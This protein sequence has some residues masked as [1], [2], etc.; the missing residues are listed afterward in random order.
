MLEREKEFRQAIETKRQNVSDCFTETQPFL[1]SVE[2]E[3]ESLR[4]Q[5]HQVKQDITAVLE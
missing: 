1:Q 3:N 4:T 2:S 5:L